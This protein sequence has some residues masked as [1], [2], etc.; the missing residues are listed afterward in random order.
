MTLKLLLALILTAA[1]GAPVGYVAYQTIKAAAQ[2][3]GMAVAFTAFPVLS[4][5]PDF[6]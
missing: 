3:R 5:A 2:L 4:L 1:I 6:R